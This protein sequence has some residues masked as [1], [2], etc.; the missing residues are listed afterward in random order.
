[1]TTPAI[2]PRR[3][4]TDRLPFRGRCK[5]KMMIG[6]CLAFF[7]GSRISEIAENFI[8]IQANWAKVM[9]RL[10]ICHILLQLKYIIPNRCAEK[11]ISSLFVFKF[12]LTFQLLAQSFNRLAKLNVRHI[13]RSQFGGQIIEK[14]FSFGLVWCFIRS[15]QLF[16]SA[17]RGSCLPGQADR[18]SGETKRA[19]NRF[20][21]QILNSPHQV[22]RMT[23]FKRSDF[24]RAIGC[25]GSS[26]LSS[27]IG[28]RRGEH[29]ARDTQN[30][31]FNW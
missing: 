12:I 11:L 10:P 2:Q 30:N 22:V 27:F 15:Q 29:F 5:S 21:I 14:R 1:M 6:I 7:K 13:G 9:Q 8:F 4:L 31:F 26:R 23:D 24:E 20:K 25:G 28:D 16:Y 17:S 19:L 18:S 3:N